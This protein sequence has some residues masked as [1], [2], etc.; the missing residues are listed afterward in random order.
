MSFWFDHLPELYPPLQETIDQAGIRS[1]N[2]DP[3]EGINYLL[4]LTGNLPPSPV[5]SM[6]SDYVRFQF[7]ENQLGNPTITMERKVGVFT[8]LFADPTPELADEIADIGKSWSLADEEGDRQVGL[9]LLVFA[10]DIF[11]KVV[12]KFD[13][14]V[15]LEMRFKIIV[16]D[17]F[18]VASLQDEAGDKTGATATA[19]TVV[20]HLITLSKERLTRIQR[21]SLN[22]ELELAA[23]HIAE[24]NP[25]MAEELMG[26]MLANSAKKT[27]DKLEQ[28]RTT[29]QIDSATEASIDSLLK[30]F[31]E[32]P[33]FSFWHYLKRLVYKENDPEAYER[34]R[35]LIGHVDK[36][37]PTLFDEAN[38]RLLPMLPVE[39]V[40]FFT[41]RDDLLAKYYRSVVARQSVHMMSKFAGECGANGDTARFETMI[42][43]VGLTSAQSKTL[44]ETYFEPV[45]DQT[46]NNN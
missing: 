16:E 45:R 5:R 18:R 43:A 28:E 41:E 9:R 14:N 3:S 46:E 25:T 19:S 6:Y 1:S 39:Q 33:G 23:L 8:A 30:S 35:W 26:V 34:A 31:G 37:F 22:Q 36:V 17:Y 20:P 4:R 40:L 13:E 42:K 21:N 12:T 10:A 32:E 2:G 15:S 11:E 44:Y 24:T 38:D 29:R 27:K 7:A